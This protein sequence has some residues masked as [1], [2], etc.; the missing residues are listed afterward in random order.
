[1]QTNHNSSFVAIILGGLLFAAT[2]IP[3]AY[4]FDATGTWEG[5]YKC[6]EFYDGYNSRYSED[7][8]LAISQVG[9]E[10]R[11]DVGEGEYFFTGLIIN[12]GAKPDIKAQVGLVSCD[13]SG[14]PLDPKSEVIRVRLTR[15]TGQVGTSAKFRGRSTYASNNGASNPWVGDCTW[16]YK[17]TSLVDP[18]VGSCSSPPPPPP[19]P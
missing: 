3:A 9:D 14:D 13:S 1:M 5:S 16:K 4:A 10:V 12:D 2:T 8:V 19:P 6:T 7:P 18:G 15:R 17:R 11:V